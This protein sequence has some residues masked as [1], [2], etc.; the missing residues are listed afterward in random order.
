V[1]DAIVRGVRTTSMRLSVSASLLAAAWAGT[2]NAQEAPVHQGHQPAGQ[3]SHAQGHATHHSPFVEVEFG[4]SDQFQ[5]GG[6]SLKLGSP[7][8]A[9]IRYFGIDGNDIGVAGLGWEFRSGGLRVI[10]GVALA[11]GRENKPAAALT[12]RW[13]YENEHWISQGT[14]VQSLGEYEPPARRE[15]EHGGEPE[16]IITY[17]SALDAIHVSRR[18]GRFEVGP[19]VEYIRYRE[20][21]AWK[22][23]GRVAVRIGH[24]LRLIAQ[25]V[26]PGTE[27]RAGAVVEY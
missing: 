24:S 20:E 4:G 25:V 11:F 1:G 3:A 21:N 19:M 9:E 6:L 23:G 14:W 27:V 12:A 22:G 2:A 7:L 26:G 15:H 18:L 8:R 5:S 16:D 10:P 13:V 17:A